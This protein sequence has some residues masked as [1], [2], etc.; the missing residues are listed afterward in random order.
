M[1][2]SLSNLQQSDV[3]QIKQLESELGITL[4]AFS[5]HE[6]KPTVLDKNALEKIQFAETKL[7]LS[8]V[9]VEH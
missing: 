1:L 3:H 6:T 9:A 5:C 4:L 2:C 7:G 8:L